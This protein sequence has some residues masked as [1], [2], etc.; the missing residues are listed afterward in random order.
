MSQTNLLQLSHFIV[1]DKITVHVR[2]ED[3]CAIDV[4]YKI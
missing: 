4:Y 1:C 3:V 2:S